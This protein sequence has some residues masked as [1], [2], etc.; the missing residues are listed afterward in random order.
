ME[1]FMGLTLDV[2]TYD[3]PTWIQGWRLKATIVPCFWPRKHAPA[4]R[5]LAGSNHPEAW[6]GNGKCLRK[7]QR[8]KPPFGSG[9]CCEGYI[10]PLIHHGFPIKLARKDV[11]KGLIAQSLR[12]RKTMMQRCGVVFSD[13]NAT[14]MGNPDSEISST[15]ELLGFVESSGFKWLAKN[16]PATDWSIPITLFRTKLPRALDDVAI[17]KL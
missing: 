1:D 3:F 5:Q 7:S 9:I 14:E 16:L 11:P 13:L 2:E 15:T 10:T 4:P 12:P 6:H 8:T 17:E